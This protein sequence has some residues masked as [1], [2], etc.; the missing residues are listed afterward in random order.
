MQSLLVIFALHPLALRAGDDLLDHVAW[1]GKKAVVLAFVL[2]DCPISSQMIP[3]LNRISHDYQERGVGLTLI[4][5]DQDFAPAE[6]AKDARDRE[7]TFPFLLDPDHRLARQLGITVVPQAVVFSADRKV[8]YR[9]RIND[10]FLDLQKRQL[11]PATQDLRVALDAILQGKE[12]PPPKADPVG[13]L[14]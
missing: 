10:L 14:L 9:G 4:Y 3:E 12:P 8:K 2:H 11:R 6:A 7:V 13:C 5:V 1:T